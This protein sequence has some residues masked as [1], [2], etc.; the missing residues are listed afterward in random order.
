VIPSAESVETSVRSSGTFA[1]LV[2]AGLV[3]YG[4]FH[5]LIA[6][7]SIRLSVPGL[8]QIPGQGAVARLAQDPIGLA[9]L[10]LL[11]VGFAML[12]LWQAVAG[13]V[14][15][16]H[17]SGR[18]RAIMRAGAGCRAATFAFLTL[19]VVRAVLD[20][21]PSSAT[22]QSPRPAS[23]GALE[24][25]LGRLVLGGAGI[26]VVAVGVGLAIFGIRRQFLDQLDDAARRGGRRV[27]IVVL[28][29]VG[30]V[31]KG[32]AFVVIGVLVVWAAVTDD[33]RQTGG[34]DQSLERLVG[35]PLGSV[36]VTVVG[37]GIGC[38]GLYLLARARHLSPRTLTS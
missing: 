7:A 33:P 9:L 16:R 37:A 11:A 28:G 10:L 29:Q 35:A 38:F 22:N 5:L 27:P 31:A 8:P 30:Y 19:S 18:R 1:W 21:K 15:H 24:Q 2:R 12:A 20:R 4:L 23:A 3:G 14:G 6:A 25:P 26:V 36:A 13:F 34:L 17:L 32:V